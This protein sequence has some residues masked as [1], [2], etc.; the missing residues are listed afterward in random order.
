MN[1]RKIPEGHKRELVQ[2][3]LTGGGSKKNRIAQLLGSTPKESHPKL[4]TESAPVPVYPKTNTP[5]KHIRESMQIL[6]GIKENKE[7][8]VVE[9][10]VKGET[11]S[12]TG[13]R[14]DNSLT[15]LT[16]RFVDLIQ[17]S[18]DKSVDLNEASILL[19]VKKRRLYDITNVLEGTI[20][21][22]YIIYIYI[23]GIGLVCKIQKNMVKWKGTVDLTGNNNPKDSSSIQELSTEL[24]RCVEEE[25]EL[26]R[27]INRLEKG[28]KMV[29]ED[30]L[31][32]E[33]GYLTY[34]DISSV[35]SRERETLIAIR[36]ERGTTIEIISE[37]ENIIG[38]Q[39][40]SHSQ[41]ITTRESPGGQRSRSSIW[42]GCGDIGDIGG[43]DIGDVGGADIGDI[44]GG[45]HIRADIGGPD[46]GDVGEADIGDI[47]GGH[48]RADI[49]GDIRDIRDIRDI[50]DN[51]Q[52]EEIGPNYGILI[53]TGGEQE[54][55]VYV[56]REGNG[57]VICHEEL[58]L[59]NDLDEGNVEDINIIDGRMQGMEI[60]AADR[61]TQL[62]HEQSVEHI[63][64]RE[65]DIPTNILPAPDTPHPN[66]LLQHNI[67]DLDKLTSISAMF[68]TGI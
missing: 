46:I 19:D 45:G 44:G 55:S 60:L 7:R 57:E 42:S 21:R 67:V 14:T 53:E 65:E 3:Y 68:A 22:I 58:K 36:A 48:I 33:Y 17:L 43:V 47:G 9:E 18:L 64:A 61:S 34:E 59:D 4:P 16:K 10:K 26:D 51:Q 1:K 12:E 40:H 62:Y 5:L 54:I 38:G 27:W 32:T 37:P 56:I 50:G 6:A 49:E 41:S 24:N 31:Y 11:I 63:H 66:I 28:L 25:K 52:E 8:K 30:E 39:I 2:E 29:G 23:L 13:R 35:L 20:Y 15:E